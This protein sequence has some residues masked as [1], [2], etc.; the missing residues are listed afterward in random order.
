MTP[1]PSPLPSGARAPRVLLSGVVLGQP[2][3]GVLRHNQELLPRVVR[4]LEEGGGA[5]AVLQ[6]RRPISVELPA[7]V[8]VLSSNVP[9]RPLLVRARRERRALVAQLERAEREGH[10]FDLVHT[11][12]LPVPRRLPVPFTLTLHDL[13]SLE[14]GHTPPIEPL[15]RRLVARRVVREAVGAAACV[16]AVSEHVR[17]RLERELGVPAEHL[18]VVPNA[19]DHFE[20]LP[21]SAGPDAPILFVGH[22]EPRKNLELLLRALATDPELPDLWLAGAPKGDEGRRLR[23]AAAALGVVER[24]RFLGA[25]D[26]EELPALYASAACLVLP[27]VV[28]GFG[29][30]VLEAQRAGVPVAVADAGALPEVAGADA[31]RFPIGDPEACA[32]AIRAAIATGPEALDA[33]ARGARARSWDASAR[34]WYEAWCA[35]AAASAA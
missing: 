9:E 11:A 13:R 3:G 18:A 25:F 29:I 31:P 28:E 34:L 6:G 4:L 8:E 17:E 1:E 30:P 12:H 22:L 16:I 33:A 23:A 2:M 32:R 7:S 19:A 35:C 10:P 24:V 20:P 26:D 15:G 5:L 21:R 27:S 14:S